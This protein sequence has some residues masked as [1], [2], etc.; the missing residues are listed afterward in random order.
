M[1]IVSIF[2]LP[3]I[4]SSRTFK[5]NVADTNQNVRAGDRLYFDADFKYPENQVRQDLRVKYEIIQN[6]VIAAESDS[7]KAVE[8]QMQFYDYILVPT[9]IMS[10]PA[11]LRVTLST[12]QNQS[13]SASAS[14]NVKKGAEH[15]RQYAIIIMGSIA[16]ISLMISLQV[17]MMN[18]RTRKIILMALSKDIASYS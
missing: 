15:V 9:S 2:C 17:Y 6:G 18:I 13:V 16:F 8:T 12:Y 10:G 3:I 11:V 5:V 14:F 7:L 4:A 1:M